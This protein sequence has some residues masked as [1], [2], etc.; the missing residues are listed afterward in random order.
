MIVGIFNLVIMVAVVVAVVV[1]IARRRK[2]GEESGESSVERAGVGVRRFFQ[3]LVMLV[4]L[5]LAGIGLAGLLDAVFSDEATTDSAAVARSIAF[6]VV[7]LPVFAG[8]AWYT[9]RRLDHP[10]EVRSFGW[11]A[12]LTMALIG[13]LVAA[14]VFLTTV[15]DGLVVGDGLDR[16]AAVSALIW[17][18]VWAGHRWA[19]ARRGFPPRMRAEHLLGSA[20][21]LIAAVIGA[22]T[23]LAQ[24][25]TRL[26]D[27]V[28]D[29]PVAAGSGDEVVTS[30][31]VLVVGFAAWSWYWLAV[32]RHEPR[33]VWWN[34]YVLLLGVLGGV[35]MVASGVGVIVF[36]T[37]DW[38]FTDAGVGASV[39]FDAVPAALGVGIVGA[40]V[41]LYHRV[42]IG[43][44]SLVARSE[45]DRVYEYLISAAGLLIVAA[46]ITTLIA[47]GLQVLS[48]DWAGED[49]GEPA[50][51]ALTLLATGLPLWLVYWVRSQRARDMAPLPELGSMSRRIYLFL[52]F[53]ATGL[54]ALISLIVGV[55]IVFEDVLDDVLGRATVSDVAVA[56]GLF[57]T[58]GA[59]AGYHF[60]VYRQDRIEMPHEAR[61]A[62]RDVYVVTAQGDDLAAALRGTNVRVHLMHTASPPLL[63]PTVDEVL[64]A[65]RNETHPQVVV[66]ETGG[67]EFELLPIE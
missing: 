49:L 17:G 43:E 29:L 57:V 66:V 61:P 22:A 52:L 3:Y 15:A 53:G 38:F 39:H 4:T 11:A 40:A 26:Y 10:S 31:V 33:S 20:A 58:A 54:V 24:V 34:A 2:P 55:Y 6:V 36:T 44:R 63:A 21:G 42:I 13:S 27:E 12:Y 65:L 48:G 60:Y 41:W 56:I 35:A 16:F 51:I 7:G 8:L 25:L 67:G 9:R 62:L 30:M 45:V 19:A 14:M 50:A 46:G 37:L 28:F 5:V 32:A 18:A 1:L 47:G 64:A 23:A 59:V